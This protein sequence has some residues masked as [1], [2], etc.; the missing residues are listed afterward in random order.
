MEIRS[1]VGVLGCGVEGRA[2]IDYLIESE[3]EQITALDKNRVDGLP[4][5]I[6]AVFGDDYDK[7]LKRFATIFRSPGIRPDHPGLKRAKESGCVVTSTLSFFLHRCPA[8]M[9]G[10]TGTVGKDHH[11]LIPP[12]VF[13][14]FGIQR[15]IGHQPYAGGFRSPGGAGVV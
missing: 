6:T 5:G 11:S 13:R 9:I 15:C 7:D 4:G 3:I 10:V 14:V 8:L 2:V 1:P 12:A